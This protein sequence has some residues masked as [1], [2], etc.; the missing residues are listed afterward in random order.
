MRRCLY[1]L[2]HGYYS[3]SHSPVGKQGDFVTSPHLS[4]LFSRLL[5]N[6]LVHFDRQLGSPEELSLVELGAE[7]EFLGR[8]LAAFLSAEHP[9]LW[10][11]ARYVPV[12]A[13]DPIPEQIEG[14]VFSNEFFDALPVRRIRRQQNRLWEVYVKR[15]AH[16]GGLEEILHDVEDEAVRDF[17]KRGFGP[18]REGWTYEVNLEMLRVLQ[19]LNHQILRAVV[20]TFDYGFSQAEYHSL[21]RPGGTLLCYRKHG[22][23]ADPYRA[24]GVDDMTAHVNFEVLIDEGERLGWLHQPLCSQR[25]FLVQWGLHRELARQEEAGGFSAQRFAER[26]GIRELVKPAGISD[27]IRVLVQFVRI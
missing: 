14:I 24:P 3:G 20:L 16:H 26:L 4:P 18:L 21:E 12:E 6:A 13:G 22:V 10:K 1:D 7:R 8:Q 5:G 9:Q 17:L 23:H 25:D 19:E 2:E 15:A 27:T 11:R